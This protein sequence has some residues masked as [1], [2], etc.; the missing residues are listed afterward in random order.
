MTSA[1][2]AAAAAAQQAL[3]LARLTYCD[4]CGRDVGPHGVD[5]LEHY[6]RAHGA[7]ID[8][9]VPPFR[10]AA[11]LHRSLAAARALHAAGEGEA[12]ARQRLG[13]HLCVVEN[14]YPM[15]PA[16]A[17]A[18]LR[19][20]TDRGRGTVALVYARRG[21]VADLQ[22][23]LAAD[24]EADGEELGV[25][26]PLRVLTVATH[27][28]HT[29]EQRAYCL[30]DLLARLAQAA[31]RPRLPLPTVPFAAPDGS[32]RRSAAAAVDLPEMPELPTA[33]PAVTVVTRNRALKRNL[34]ELFPWSVQVAA[35]P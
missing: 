6:A 12:A 21:D 30:V 1:S 29:A 31:A 20:H 33:A 8:A 24:L 18:F 32:L 15:P 22:E 23:Q 2:D 27:G 28:P 16:I 9:R 4:Q 34:Q 19:R 3:H 25:P 7:C 11:L 35:C 14:P 5:A 17:R 13:G 10:L 26:T